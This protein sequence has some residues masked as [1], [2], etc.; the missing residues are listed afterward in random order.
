MK[1]RLEEWQREREAV[2]REIQMAN[3]S[4]VIVIDS[5]ATGPPSPEI[6]A[7]GNQM[8]SQSDEEADPGVSRG[9]ELGD[10]QAREVYDEDIPDQDVDLGGSPQHDFEP[11]QA[12]EL[13]EEEDEE[14]YEDIWQQEARD[15]SNISHRSSALHR[16]ENDDVEARQES[17]PSESSPAPSEPRGIFSPKSWTNDN[18]KVPFWAIRASRNCARRQ[19][20]FPL[21]FVGRKPLGTFVAIMVKA[22]L[23]KRVRTE[24]HRS[25]NDQIPIFRK[26]M[27][28]IMGSKTTRAHA[29][30]WIQALTGLRMM[31][32]FRSTLLQGM[33]AKCNVQ[34]R[35]RRRS[36]TSIFQLPR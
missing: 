24:I 32:H 19:W 9:Q 12:E 7:N 18:A 10:Y 20:I 34:T 1:R 29:S 4:Q 33:R 11:N 21:C 16:R 23:L 26:R 36:R 6:D 27:R 25:N 14:G 31:T 28:K 8:G 17:N 3:A 15:H 2:S 5:D 35:W 22:A 13:Y 30:I